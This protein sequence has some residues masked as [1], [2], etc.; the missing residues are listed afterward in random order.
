[1]AF[2]E[3]DAKRHLLKGRIIGLVESTQALGH[4]LIDVILPPKCL[5]C[6][7]RIDLAHNICPAC[8]K[9]LHFLSDPMCKCCGYP[10]G[11]DLGVN[12]TEIGDSLCGHC[13]GLGR[14][15]D[16]SLS[17]LRYDDNSKRMIIGF[18]HQDKLE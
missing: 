2:L 11:D 3:A 8:W 16:Q 1:M 10:F 7:G 12:Y 9:E 5:N 14:A 18:K 15:F 4:K 13:Q 17:A 6:A